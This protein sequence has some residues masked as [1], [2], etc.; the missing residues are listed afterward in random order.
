MFFISVN[1][2]LHYIDF[3]ILFYDNTLTL[4]YAALFS[5]LVFQFCF[6]MGFFMAFFKFLFLRLLCINAVL[7]FLDIFSSLHIYTHSFCISK[8]MFWCLNIFAVSMIK[9]HLHSASRSSHFL[10]L[11][12]QTPPTLYLLSDL[13]NKTQIKPKK[14]Y[15]G[16]LY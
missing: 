10:L 1:C 16:Q 14:I 6:I 15:I 2:G 5:L 4:L 7:R 12:N 8:Y 11:W 9:L 13:F 3:S